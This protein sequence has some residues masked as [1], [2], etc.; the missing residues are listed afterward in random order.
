M[1]SGNVSK[2]RQVVEILGKID[3]LNEKL[4]KLLNGHVKA[5][6]TVSTARAKQ[7]KVMGTYAGLIRRLKPA[8]AAKVKAIREDAGFDHAIKAAKVF[9]S[10]RSA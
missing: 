4:G 9:R 2:A 1:K 7:L 8:D 6:R 3:D 10:Q 5:T